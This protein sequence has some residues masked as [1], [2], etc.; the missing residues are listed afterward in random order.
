M[1]Q[2][3]QAALEKAREAL[4]AG[5]SECR[6]LHPDHPSMRQMV[7]AIAAIDALSQSDAEGWGQPIGYAYFAKS[8]GDLYLCDAKHAGLSHVFPVYRRAIAPQ[9]GQAS[10]VSQPTGNESYWNEA[11]E[12]ELVDVGYSATPAAS[13]DGRSVAWVPWHPEH[14]FD[15]T[16]L[17]HVEAEFDAK[18]AMDPGWIKL[19]L[20]PTPKASSDGRVVEVS[21]EDLAVFR[22]ATGEWS[23]HQPHEK[24]CAIDRIATAIRAKGQ[25]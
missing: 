17:E 7:E 25:K 18:G 13:S 14:G 24:Q 4:C 11:G 12:D 20:C 19:S 15:W 5:I 9:G 2:S 8:S 6:D 22:E 3:H 16:E 1:N 21:A 10:R 23:R